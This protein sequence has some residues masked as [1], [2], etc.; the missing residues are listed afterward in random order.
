MKGSYGITRPQ[1][2]A[3]R[4]IWSIPIQCLFYYHYSGSTNQI[5]AFDLIST[6]L[7]MVSPQKKVL[8]GITFYENLSCVMPDKIHFN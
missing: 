1:R 6:E 8:S 3:Q 2:K 7:S 5:V 4:Y